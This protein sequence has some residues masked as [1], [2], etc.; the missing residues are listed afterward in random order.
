MKHRI[1]LHIDMDA[2]FPSIEERENPHFQGKPIIVGADPKEGKGRGVVSSASYEA[3]KYGIK[4]GMPISK[5]WQL[6]PQGI[7]LPVNMELYQKVSNEIM[8]IIKQYSPKYEIVSL[9]EAYLDLTEYS[10]ILLNI[11]MFG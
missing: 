11:K 3:R 4:S 6:C 9:D 10:K 5:A 8:E 1:I 2:F 7:F